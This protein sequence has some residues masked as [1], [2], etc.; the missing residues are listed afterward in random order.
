MRLAV[1]GHRPQRLGGYSTAAAH[2]LTGFAAHVLVRMDPESVGIGMA[3]GWDTAVAVACLSLGIP[4]RAYVPGMWQADTWPEHSKAQWRSLLDH[5]VE[6]VICTPTLRYE[7][8]AM[9]VRNM[10]LVDDH[11]EVL[12]LWDGTPTGGTAGCV[13]YATRRRAVPRKVTNVWEEWC[14]CNS[15]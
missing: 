11:D 14:G 3:L 4:Y 7:P 6:I 2:R 9:H 10:W 13:E 1:T 15:V 5:A 8:A 12:A